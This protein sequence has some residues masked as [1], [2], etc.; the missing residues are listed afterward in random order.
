MNQKFAVSLVQG[1]TVLDYIK[2]IQPRRV[3]DRILK[4]EFVGVVS[5]N[6]QQT[7]TVYN[8]WK[9][10]YWHNISRDL[11]PEQLQIA[12][13]LHAL[14]LV[15]QHKTALVG[16]RL[17]SQAVQNGTL[18]INLYS[19]HEID[20]DLVWTDGAGTHRH[21]HVV[22]IPRPVEKRDKYLD[23]L[24]GTLLHRRAQ[25]RSPRGRGGVR[26]MG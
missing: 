23:Q 7:T 10:N 15:A 21:E 18:Q 19:E 12:S 16:L 2:Q 24:V 6:Q 22:L 17:Y 20:I 11:K 1:L 14:A 5:E 13:W 3:D 25:G 26:V 9:Y 4:G 8:P